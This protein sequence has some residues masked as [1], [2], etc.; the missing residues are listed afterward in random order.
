MKLVFTHVL[1]R[2]AEGTFFVRP[3]KSGNLFD[4][5]IELTLVSQISL[6]FDYA[7]TVGANEVV[8]PFTNPVEKEIVRGILKAYREQGLDMRVSFPIREKKNVHSD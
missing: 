6:A 7:R 1:P 2:I 5:E 4:R 3:L 8:F